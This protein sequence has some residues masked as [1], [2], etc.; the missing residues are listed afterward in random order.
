MYKKKFLIFLEYWNIPHFLFFFFLTNYLLLLLINADL[1]TSYFSILCVYVSV[2]LSYEEWTGW[3]SP[4]HWES[5]QS[6]L[7]GTQSHAQRK[8]VP[9]VIRILVKKKL[10]FHANKKSLICIVFQKRNIN[11]ICNNCG[12]PIRFSGLIPMYDSL[13]PMSSIIALDQS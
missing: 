9:F 6:I 1:I 2:F 7:F 12:L 5:R 13:D 8:P 10:T 3:M 4:W 11:Y